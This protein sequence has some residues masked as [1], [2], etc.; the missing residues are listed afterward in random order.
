MLGLPWYHHLHS[1][2]LKDTA[3]KCLPIF[4]NRLLALA[5]NYLFVPTLVLGHDITGSA[6]TLP[7]A[8][9]QLNQSQL[10]HAVLSKQFTKETKN[11]RQTLIMFQIF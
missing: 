3:F 8:M 6:T 5:Q 10:F 4:N 2:I 1:T 7:S 9:Y 11:N